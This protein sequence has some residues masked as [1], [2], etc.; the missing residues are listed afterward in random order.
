MEKK[1]SSDT[2]FLSEFENQWKNSILELKPITLSIVKDVLAN[3]TCKSHS[4]CPTCEEVRE[5]VWTFLRK[6]HE[7]DSE[8]HLDT[9]L[10][11]LGTSLRFFEHKFNHAITLKNCHTKVKENDPFHKVLEVIR[12]AYG[13]QVSLYDLPLMYNPVMPDSGDASL[14][15]LTLCNSEAGPTDLG[16]C[17]SMW[18]D[19]IEHQCH[20]KG[21]NPYMVSKNSDLEICGK[22]LG[23]AV[24]YVSTINIDL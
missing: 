5:E 4:P 9:L 3:T 12:K 11:N 16:M 15:T 8:N 22:G 13:T 1:T 19:C 6:I 17:S 23:S 2:L 24:G 18:N 7:F 14:L 21:I 10:M 20:K